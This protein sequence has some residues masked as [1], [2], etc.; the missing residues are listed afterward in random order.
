[1]SSRVKAT[2]Y[3]RSSRVRPEPRIGIRSFALWCLG[4]LRDGAG[5]V[6]SLKVLCLTAQGQHPVLRL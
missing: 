4:V 3:V 5:I 2:D 6:S 1:M